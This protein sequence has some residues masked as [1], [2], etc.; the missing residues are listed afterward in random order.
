M[1]AI[2]GTKIS[3]GKNRSLENF[4]R[5]VLAGARR[6]GETCKLA[7]GIKETSFGLPAS[8]RRSPKLVASREE[9]VEG[10]LVS[11]AN[12]VLLQELLIVKEVVATVHA[13]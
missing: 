6:A 1:A 13:G 2:D 11:N 10:H 4:L 9:L 12:T 7:V 8:G 3:G 5:D